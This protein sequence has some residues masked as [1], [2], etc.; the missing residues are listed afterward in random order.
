MSPCAPSRKSVLTLIQV[1]SV[2]RRSAHHVTAAAQEEEEDYI[3]QRNSLVE[4]AG[5]VHPHPPPPPTPRARTPPAP[6]R[7]L[8][9]AQRLQV[10]EDRGSYYFLLAC[11]CL[12]FAPFG[13]FLATRAAAKLRGE[14]EMEGGSEREG[15]VFCASP[16]PHQ[17]RGE[18]SQPKGGKH[19]S[20]PPDMQSRLHGLQHASPP[21]AARC[22]C[23]VTWLCK[24]GSVAFPVSELPPLHSSCCRC[25]CACACSLL[26]TLSSGVEPRGPRTVTRRGPC[27]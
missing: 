16:P 17:S 24:G 26:L 27:F 25:A 9:D 15:K 6:S 2:G 22:M 10:H 20:R 4:P 5:A 1:R 8:R 23:K 21:P 7:A 14:R 12:V 18:M 11:C 19:I 13:F 3:L